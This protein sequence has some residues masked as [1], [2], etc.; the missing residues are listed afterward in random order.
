MRLRH[1]ARG[2]DV[3]GQ[4]RLLLY[5]FIAPVHGLTVWCPPGGGLEGDETP[6]EALAREL[7][8]EI[9]LCDYG[10]ATHVWHEE[11]RDPT[12]LPGWDGAVNDYFLVPV[13]VAFD[14]CGSLGREALAAELVEH[15]EWWSVDRLLSHCGREVFDHAI[16]PTDSHAWS[17]MGRRVR[18][19]DLFGHCEGYEA[20]S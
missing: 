16:Y 19:I 14:P 3:D 10:A 18:R 12:I 9:G 8:E 13:P 4:S 2:L 20:F 1:S 17:R 7:D 15:F 6:P 5:R 11:I